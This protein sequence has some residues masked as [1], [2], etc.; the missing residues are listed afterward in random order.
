[1]Q[2]SFNAL[3]VSSY[4]SFFVT[5][6]PYLEGYDFDE[7]ICAS[8]IAQAQK[9]LMTK[10]ISA[11]IIDTPLSDGL[12]LDFATD[13]ADKKF[14]SVLLFAKNELYNQISEKAAPHGIFTLPENTDCVTLS[15]A[16]SVIATTA[17]KLY[18]LDSTE[19]K[20]L[21]KAE[22]LKIFSR[23]KMILI[24]SFGMSEE[25]SHKYI[26][27]RSMEMRKPKKDIALSIINSY[28]K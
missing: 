19:E 1:M 5:K 4:K 6:K 2:K 26:E 11:I 24:S 23:A 10:G 28:G 8:S 25:Q 20:C 15:E 16:I 18:S 14:Y 9:V 17:K 27:Q 21:S 7:I 12:G 22:E 3:L 13:C